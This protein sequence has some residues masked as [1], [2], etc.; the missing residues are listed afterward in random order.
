MTEIKIEKKNSIWPWLLLLL[1]ILAATWF[2]FL[3]DDEVKSEETVNKTTLIDI[4]E[5]NSRVEEYVTYI[6]SDT[7]TMSLDHTF[8]S[9]AITK[10]TNA[11]D[12]MAA[13]VGYDAKAEIEKAK[14]ISDEITKDPMSTIH[15]DKISSAAN[16]L[17]TALQ[18]MQRAKYPSLSTEA[19][20]VNSAASAISP[21]VLTLDQRDAV[22]SFFRK[23]ADLLSKMN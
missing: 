14:Q 4:Q 21:E 20:D 13:D 15:G 11:V 19:A 22:K 2:F 10:L 7:N 1:G 18:N 16:V 6:N 5:N 12:A 8:T 9:E 3:R 17:S 23:A